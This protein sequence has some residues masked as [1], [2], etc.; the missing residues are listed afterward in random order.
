MKKLLT[1]GLIAAAGFA[2]EGYKVVG[3]IKI[4]GEGR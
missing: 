2:A 1:I 4:G 3:K